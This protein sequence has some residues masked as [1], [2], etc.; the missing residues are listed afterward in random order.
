MAT[1]INWKW[2]F[3]SWREIIP[4]IFWPVA[5]IAALDVVWMAA[6]P[7]PTDRPARYLLFGAVA[8]AVSFFNA[9]EVGLPEI[10][11]VPFVYFLAILLALDVVRSAARHACPP[12]CASSRSVSRL[13]QACTSSSSLIKGTMDGAGPRMR[14][15]LDRRRVRGTISDPR[16]RTRTRPARTVWQR[17]FEDRRASGRANRRRLPQ[18]AVTSPF[19][20]W[21][22]S[23]SRSRERGDPRHSYPTLDGRATARLQLFNGLMIAVTP[24]SRQR[25]MPT[26]AG[27]VFSQARPTSSSI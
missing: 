6:R 19:I 24:R 2:G 11:F 23:R 27:S 10:R 15:P 5:A 8:A 14:P 7:H 17:G 20:Y 9:T 16:A 12:R 22:Q 26:R 18:T 1:S 21:L 13:A 3:Q 4:R 25:S